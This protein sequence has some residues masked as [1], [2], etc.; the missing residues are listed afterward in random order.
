MLS[1]LPYRSIKK[2]LPALTCLLAAFAASLSMMMSCT[3]PM[4]YSGSKDD[5]YSNFDALARIV[6]ERY[7]FF[8]QKEID[9]NEVT[10]KSRAQITSSTGPVE[11]FNIMSGMLDSLRDG[12]VNLI[13]PFA[14]SYYKKWWSDYPQDFNER[15][16]QEYYLKFGGYQK[17][18]MTY[19]IFLPDTVGYVRIPSFGS[20]IPASTLDYI[21]ASM[22][23]TTGLIIDIRD[24]GGGYLTNV[25]EVVGRF[26]TEKITG[27]YI[28]HKTGPGPED[29]S[30]PFKIEYEPAKKGHIQYL[31]RRIILLTN[32]SCFSAAN[33]FTSVMKSLPNV[34][35]VG[36]RT[37][38]GGGL[39]FSSELPNGWSIRFSSCPINDAEDRITEFGIRPD[40]EVHCTPEELAAGRDAILEYALNLF[41]TGQK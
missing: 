20:Q 10:A 28:R 14:N 7:C 34:T 13:A 5:P 27:G 15:T 26:I 4:T 39:P 3:E 21:L 41:H 33:D 36:A 24:N 31:G 30:K 17:A 11:L 40:I 19:C 29:F 32:R 1:P 12:H 9:W 8:R 35:Q 18:G 23:P 25:P 6:G 16:L 2:R 22:E 37:G 38:G